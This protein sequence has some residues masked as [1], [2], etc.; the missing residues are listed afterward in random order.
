MEFHLPFSIMLKLFFL[1]IEKYHTLKV[2]K[3]KAGWKLSS[4]KINDRP[5]LFMQVKKSICLISKQVGS[6]SKE[7]SLRHPAILLINVT[8]MAHVGVELCSPELLHSLHQWFSTK[9][10][11]GISESSSGFFKIHFLL[12]GQFWDACPSGGFI[13]LWKL[14]RRFWYNYLVENSISDL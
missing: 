11:R 5:R 13:W 2:K 6:V 1:V 10:Y 3:W 9:E 4:P 12:H 14:S 8:L 7:D